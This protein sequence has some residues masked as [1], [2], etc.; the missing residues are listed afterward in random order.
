VELFVAGCHD[1]DSTRHRS[2]AFVID[3]KL[4][5]GAGGLATGLNLSEQNALE[6]V[7]LS[8][9]QFDQIRDLALLLEH[10]AACGAPPLT[11]IAMPGTLSILKTHVFNGVVC[12]DFTRVRAANGPIMRLKPYKRVPIQWGDYRLQGYPMTGPKLALG[13]TVS[14]KNRA[15]AYGGVQTPDAKF[16]QF[17]GET[18]GLQLALIAV[19]FP[20]RSEIEARKSGRYTPA[21]LTRDLEK[22]QIAV[23]LPLL[24][25]HMKPVF[26]TQIEK[27]C[28]KLPHRSLTVARLGDRYQV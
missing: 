12:R 6:L 17:L 23:D 18:A 24:V 27:E 9:P 25:F 15:L 1:G 5:L 28:G 19:G 10:R 3:G 7:W 14:R 21:G 8:H 2:S 4:A 16:W 20:N 26:A 13:C 22:Y 11:L